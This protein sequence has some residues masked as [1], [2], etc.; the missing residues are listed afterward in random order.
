M[1]FGAIGAAALMLSGAA[2][3]GQQLPAT[4]AAAPAQGSSPPLVYSPW[5][6]F[7]STPGQNAIAPKVCFTGREI[8]TEAGESVVAAALIEPDGAA[9]KIF[10]VTVQAP[11]QLRYGTRLIV[12]HGEPLTAPYFT[13]SANACISDYNGTA[14]LIAKLKMGQTLDIQ[15]VDLAGNPVSFP[16]PLAAFANA[17]E[18]PPMDAKQVA[19]ERKK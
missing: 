7:C 3:F 6:K 17:L 16:L 9:S 10:R 19:E 1:L 15:A 18:G 5:T 13:C 11:L 8:L 12:D 14:E 2:G 4:G